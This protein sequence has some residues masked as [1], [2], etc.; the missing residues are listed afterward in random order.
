MCA[1]EVLTYLK[2]LQNA[3]SLHSRNLDLS[4]AATHTRPTRAKSSNPRCIL[5]FF[6]RKIAPGSFPA[7]CGL[8]DRA[9]RC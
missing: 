9:N 2:R 8:C 5:P 6:G 4:T 7:C 1:G 3:V